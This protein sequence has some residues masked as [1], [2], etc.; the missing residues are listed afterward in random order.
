MTLPSITPPSSVPGARR[1]MTWSCS[2]AAIGLWTVAR[3]WPDLAC[4]P[5]LW[6]LQAWACIGLIGSALSD[7]APG[8]RAHFSAAA[9]LLAMVLFDP[10]WQA[11]VLAHVQAQAQ[12]GGAAESIWAALRAIGA[13]RIRA[14]L[15]WHWLP[16]LSDFSWYVALGGLAIGW[17]S[18]LAIA[19]QPVIARPV[20]GIA[21]V[22]FALWS[23]LAV[24]YSGLV[25]TQGLHDVPVWFWI[26]ML[27]VLPWHWRKKGG[28]LA[29][30]LWLA[31]AAALLVLGLRKLVDVV[32]VR[33]VLFAATLAVSA[34]CWL[35][36]YIGIEEIARFN[37]L[38]KAARELE[39]QQTEQARLAEQAAAVTRVSAPDTGFDLDAHLESPQAQEGADKYTRE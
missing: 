14:Q 23:A 30:L 8:R 28:W 39:K 13:E 15:P 9:V 22:A 12:A 11:A 5:V 27:V 29:I 6:G 18:V 10:W 31:C 34:V 25:L 36:W 2:I 35:F 1:F 16:G 38:A 4:A 33:D 17:F 3:Y 37:T 7:D 20:R 24:L 26:M 21:W 32:M 19:Q